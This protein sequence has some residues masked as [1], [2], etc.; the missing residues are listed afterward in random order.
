MANT[1]ASTTPVIGFHEG[2]ILCQVSEVYPG[3]R[4][5][6]LEVI[7]NALD[8]NA[9]VVY[10]GID[11]VNHRVA[12]M[13]NG[14]GI[15]EEKFNA[16]IALIGETQKDPEPGTL[17]RFGL[18]LVAP[19]TK[20]ETMTI[21]SRPQGQTNVSQWLFKQDEIRKH[22]SNIPIP[23]GKVPRF[24]DMPAPFQ[25]AHNKARRT[26]GERVEWRTMV[27]LDNVSSDKTISKVEIGELTR[28]IR[29]KF[30]EAMHIKKATVFVEIRDADN[31]V[32]Q[33]RV[34]PTK[35]TGKRLPSV[36]LNVGKAG[37]VEFDLYEARMSDGKRV[38]AGVRFG[39]IKSINRI[40]VAE[41]RFQAMNNGWYEA[42]NPEF[43]AAIR[44]LESGF[45][46]G[47]VRGEFVEI[48][49]HRTGFEVNDALEDFYVAIS[50]WWKH[51]GQEQFEGGQQ[52]LKDARYQQLGEQS[53]EEL[54]GLIGGDPE[55]SRLFDGVLPA[56]RTSRPPKK[57][58]ERKPRKL[59]DPGKRRV[60]AR[61]RRKPE[62][63]A[64]SPVSTIPN[65]E[66]VILDEDLLWDYDPGATT[67]YLNVSHPQWVMLDDEKHTEVERNR[68]LRL[69]QEY[70]A[71]EL[72]MLLRTSSF[73][74]DFVEKRKEIDEKLPVYI[75]MFIVKRARRTS[76]KK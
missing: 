37:K 44:A 31:K 54:I 18:G 23:H 19:V 50:E 69:L 68:K 41:F 70:I 30:G 38:G 67:I 2:K 66:Y 8:A 21:L 22:A 55:L 48:N 28:Q 73:M 52:E 29:D 59:T 61:P 36:K 15:T 32:K 24:H 58:G 17:G 11:Q 62:G 43:Y 65:F 6:V 74:D 53:I 1:P 49:R 76:L 33:Q 57:E 42:G 16:A 35:F 20:C 75:K 5:A 56:A 12:V 25:H 26:K 63:S 45:F 3:L 64:G 4:K 7:Q 40:P 51:H 27:L 71:Y 10:V 9:K 60:I 13:D 39:E 47:T 46:E 34:D 14:S 72:L